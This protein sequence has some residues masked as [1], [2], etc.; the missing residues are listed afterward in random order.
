MP[1]RSPLVC[2]HNV[3]KEHIRMFGAKIKKSCVGALGSP[4]CMHLVFLPDYEPNLKP[5]CMF[6]AHK[7]R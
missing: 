7:A 4:Y 2:W 5:T 3:R 1:R 6:V